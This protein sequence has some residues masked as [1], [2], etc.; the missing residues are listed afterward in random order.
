MTNLEIMLMVVVLVEAVLLAYYIS[1]YQMWKDTAICQGGVI[2]EIT[3]RAKERRTVD[4][5]EQQS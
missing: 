3:D 2:K 5:G 4:E 1:G